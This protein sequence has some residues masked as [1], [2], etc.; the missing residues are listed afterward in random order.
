LFRKA[1]TLAATVVLGDTFGVTVQNPTV[2]FGTLN[3]IR[4]IA[5]SVGNRGF[6]YVGGPLSTTKVDGTNTQFALEYDDGV[7]EIPAGTLPG[8]CSPAAVA[9]NTGT[10]PDE[11]GNHWTQPYDARCAGWW[12]FMAATT[13]TITWRMSLYAASSNTPLA[14]TTFDSDFTTST[15]A[16]QYYGAWTDAAS[17]VVLAAGTAY[18]LTCVALSASSVSVHRTTVERNAFFGSFGLPGIQETS[19]NRSSTTDPDGAAW[20]ETST[21][22]IQ[23]GMI[24]DQIDDG[25]GSGGGLKGDGTGMMRHVMYR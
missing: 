16:R 17:G 18:R 19:R 12:A 13:A 4:G 11:I 20:A 21:Q 25:A 7:I 23:M 1:L 5:V 3:I 22:M 9:I 6:P 15:V 10:N 2:S 14:T 8:A 24:I